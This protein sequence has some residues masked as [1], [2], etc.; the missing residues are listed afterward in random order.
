MSIRHVGMAWTLVAA[1]A[2]AMVWG[3][4]L[5]AAEAEE[6]FRA[7]FDGVSLEGW[8]GNPDLWSVQ[9][10]VICGQ[11]TAEKPTRGNTFLI[12]RAGTVADFE[13]RLEYRIENHNSGVQYRSV[14]R[15]NFVVQGYQADIDAGNRYT[16]I[17]YEEG[18]RGIVC[19]RGKKMRVKPEGGGEV[20][21]KTCEEA[22]AAAVLRKEDWN[23]YV[24]T[25]R[26]NHLVH[27][28]N[29]VVTAEVIDEQADKRRLEGVLAFQLH[30][31]PPMK[32][33]FRN[34]RL[35]RLP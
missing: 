21:G 13:L 23:E 20:V 19:P 16:G 8:E 18:G 9:D 29:G 31:G 33:Q 11:T 14:D 30:A 1:M 35:R 12:W 26:G 2:W 6:G 4:L 7:I 25:A 24:I 28:I 34:I 17:L 22:E 5:A 27:S 32:V 10:G 15:G 3:G